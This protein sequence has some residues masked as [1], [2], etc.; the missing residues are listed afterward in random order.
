MAYSTVSHEKALH[1][2]FIPC[3]NLRK[4]YET[5]RKSSEISG[6]FPKFRNRFKT[7]FE[8]IRF[9]KFSENLRKSSEFFR[10]VRK[11]FKL[12]LYKNFGKYSELFGNLRK[13]LENF[14]NG[15]KLFFRIFKIFSNFRKS[16]EVLGNHRKICR[17]NRN[18]S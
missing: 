9:W 8:F 14:G 5:I 12:A 11:R 17:G 16:S 7:V 13:F 3:L 4:I 15:W 6:N 2:Y 18:C 10:K 1:N